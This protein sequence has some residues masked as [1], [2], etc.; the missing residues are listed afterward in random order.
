MAVK[1]GNCKQHHETIADVRAC[2]QHGKPGSSTPP[3]PVEATSPVPP[4]EKQIDFAES[5]LSDRIWPDK[6]TR[7]ELKLMSRS[8]VSSLITGLKSAEYKPQQLNFPEGRYALEEDIGAD[9]DADGTGGSIGFYEVD[10]WHGRISV[11]H[12]VGA[13]GDFA[14]YPMRNGEA[15]RIL[16]AIERNP[17]E[18][19]MRFADE[20]ECCGSCGSPLTNAESRAARIGP[21]CARKSEIIS[22]W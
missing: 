10:M 4:S 2:F 3:I 13:P 20:T 14:K 22:I 11:R 6:Y 16:A 19:M 9:T 8:Q 7:D 17:K 21:V 15:R 18:A 5:L 1:C 12:L